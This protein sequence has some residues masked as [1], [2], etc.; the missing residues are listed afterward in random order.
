LPRP[1]LHRWTID[2][3]EQYLPSAGFLT[4]QETFDPWMALKQLLYYSHNL[5]S[6]KIFGTGR[7]FAFDFYGFFSLQED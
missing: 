7:S 5:V 6:L 2:G 1:I 3:L 4:A